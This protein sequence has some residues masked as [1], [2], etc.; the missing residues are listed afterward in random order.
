METQKTRRVRGATG[1]MDTLLVALEPE[2]KSIVEDISSAT[3]LSMGI[4]EE[5]IIA[6]MPEV[7]ELGELGEPRAYRESRTEIA[8]MSNRVSKPAK[9]K[10]ERLKKMNGKGT[11][12]SQVFDYFIRRLELGP[13]GVPVSWAATLSRNTSNQQT[14]PGLFE[15]GLLITGT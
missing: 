12:F 15:G 1:P 11:S 9:K 2:V 3:S 14:I 6:E 13:D 4:V 5:L 8:V 10:V 7:I